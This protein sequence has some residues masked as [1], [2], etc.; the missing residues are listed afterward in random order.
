MITFRMAH[1]STRMVTIVEVLLDGEV[2]ATI[3]PGSETWEP[4]V[5]R[6]F[7]YHLTTVSINEGD[8]FD[9]T[10]D[11]DPALLQCQFVR[12]P[13]VQYTERPQRETSP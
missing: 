11:A 12:R 6:M 10:D 4:G 5:L 8:P 3:Y 7:S 2:C 13:D 9:V 1:H